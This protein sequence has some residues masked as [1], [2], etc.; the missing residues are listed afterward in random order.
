MRQQCGHCGKNYRPNPN[1][2]RKSAYCSNRC[3]AQR[4]QQQDRDTA[5]L[6][7][8]LVR[9]LWEERREKFHYVP[10]PGPDTIKAWRDEY[11]RL[12]S[13]IRTLNE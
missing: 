7:M 3:R 12:G 10:R 2:T 13:W 4:I 11:N 8:E 1:A 9:Q 5:W 6:L